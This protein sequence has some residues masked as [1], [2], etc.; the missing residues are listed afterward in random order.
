MSGWLSA[1]DRRALPFV[2]KKNVNA[3]LER[4]NDIGSIVSMKWVKSRKGGFSRKETD[5]M[6]SLKAKTH[7]IKRIWFRSC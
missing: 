2:K 7:I 4:T 3:K 6:A 5:F 1:Q